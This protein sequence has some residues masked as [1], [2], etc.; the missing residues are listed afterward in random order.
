[1][2]S[3]ATRQTVTVTLQAPLPHSQCGQSRPGGDTTYL[4]LFTVKGELGGHQAGDKPRTGAG[5]TEGSVGSKQG[6]GFPG[7][8]STEC[9]GD[10]EKAGTS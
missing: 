1:M 6:Q 8:H 2:L 10:K 5:S 7:C 9:P 4:A 3:P